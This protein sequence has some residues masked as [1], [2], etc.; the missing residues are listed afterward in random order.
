MFQVLTKAK[1]Y[2]RLHL[3]DGFWEQLNVQNKS[4]KIWSV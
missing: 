1:V 2:N 4:L 3:S